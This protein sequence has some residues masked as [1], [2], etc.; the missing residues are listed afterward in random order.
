M[1]A[2]TDLYDLCAEYLSAA[3]DALLDTPEGVA[4]DRQYVSLGIPPW[5][6]EQLTVHAG[7]PAV[8]V[9]DTLP[10]QPSLVPLQRVRTQ[11]FVN[12]VV[13]TATVIRCMPVTDDSGNPPDTDDLAAAAL[14][15]YSDLWAV[16]NH[17]KA[18]VRAGTLFAGES[19]EFGLDPVVP[20]G[21]EGGFGGWQ[22]PVRVQLGGY[23]PS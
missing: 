7:G 9:A 16:W 2:S 15:T 3:A 1:G 20:I 21:P 12:I 5:D 17:V 4:P 6:C 22:I 19:R 8:V 23:K 11:G 10:L 14:Q 13:M 18:E